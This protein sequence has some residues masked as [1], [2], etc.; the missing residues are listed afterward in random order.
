MQITKVGKEDNDRMSND[1][2]LKQL[3]SAVQPRQYSSDTPAVCV[4]TK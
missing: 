1:R 2:E 3:T 4:V